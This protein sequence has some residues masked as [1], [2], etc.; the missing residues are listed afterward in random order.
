MLMVKLKMIGKT[1]YMETGNGS[2]VS[3]KS[4]QNASSCHQESRPQATVTS[5]TNPEVN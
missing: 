4:D 5:V 1:G 3:L 2:K